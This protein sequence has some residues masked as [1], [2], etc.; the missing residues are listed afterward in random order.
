MP[1]VPRELAEH[2][3][4][5]DPD[6]RPIKQSLCPVNEEHHCAIGEEVNRLLTAG[7]IM[8]VK[9]PKWLAN[10][11]LVLKKK[12][13]WRMCID[14][15]NLNRACPKDPFVLPRINQIIDSIAGSESPCFLDAY[16]GYNQ[17]KMAIED[18]EKTSFITLFDAYCYTTMSFGLKNAGATY[19]RCMQNCLEKQIRHNVHVYVDD[20]VVKSTRK[21]DLVADLTETFANLRG[22]VASLSR[23]IPRLGEKAMPLYRLLKMSASFYWT[24]EA[25]QALAA[26]KTALQEAP[27]LAAAAPKET[28]LMYIAATNRVVSTVMV[29]ERPEEGKEHLVQLPMYYFSEE[30]PI[31]VI[32]STPFSNIIRNRDATGRIAKWAV[33]IGVH[34]ISYEPRKAI[35]SQALADFFVDWEETQQPASCSEVEYWMLY[36]D[37]SKNIDGA[38]AD[39]VL[40]SPKG[41][42]LRYVLQITFQPCSNNVAEY[43]SPPPGVFLDV[44]T[45]P[46]VA[47]PKEIGL[48]V[49]PPPDSVLVSVVTERTDWTEPYVPYLEHQ[50]LPKDESKARMIVRRCKAFV[51][52]D[53]ELYKRSVSGV[54]Q[55]CVSPEEG[56]KILY[57]IHASDCGHHAGARSLVAKAF[58]HS[59]YWLSAHADDVD[60]VCSCVGCQK[61]GNQSHLPR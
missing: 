48:L 38:G 6:A 4:H 44:L 29:V 55:R 15:T 56:R 26:I 46:S 45:R 57:D 19:Q 14:Y 23:F 52:I 33:E 40:T 12:K 1:G 3:L 37:G 43:E 10:P 41:D 20:M 31:T 21:D 5:V 28:M 61:Y 13:T 11:V 9:H 60:I 54:F 47:P 35:K 8:E 50:I 17:I 16:S 59:F 27:I 22:R 58:R 25:D 51:M 34:N 7:F 39:V 42:K 32:A 30:H 49:P 36:F 24:S 2:K 18:Q 53:N